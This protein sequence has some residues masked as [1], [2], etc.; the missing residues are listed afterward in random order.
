[1]NI[2]NLLNV[3]K[4]VASAI[5]NFV[6]STSEISSQSERILE[7]LSKE[8]SNLKANVDNTILENMSEAK[9]ASEDMKNLFS[10]DNSSMTLQEKMAIAKDLLSKKAKA[11]I[12]NAIMYAFLSV[13]SIIDVLLAIG[14]TFVFLTSLITAKFKSELSTFKFI[15]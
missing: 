8:F 11:H 12:D 4:T 6:N 10:E 1:M 13:L 2:L 9:K 7:E 5:V 14:E 15:I 3:T